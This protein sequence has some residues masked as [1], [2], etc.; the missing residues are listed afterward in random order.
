MTIIVGV[1]TP[2]GWGI[3]ADSGAFEDT[4]LV[5]PVGEPKCW[6]V[7]NSY[8]GA[9]G[10]FRAMEVA[11]MSGIS[12]P[13]ALRDR[14]AEAQ[15]QGEWNVLV[16]TPKGVFEIDD[17]F[18]VLRVRQEYSAIG[19]ANTVAIGALAIANKHLSGNELL[20]AVLKATAMHSVYAR[21][22]FAK[23]WTQRGE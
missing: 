4:G 9:S 6:K 11:R 13:Y 23:M 1:C 16:V 2:K 7:H 15:V 18:S 3:G 19:A 21:P 22:P 14:L 17:S 20:D 10:S 5:Q 8:V 12:E